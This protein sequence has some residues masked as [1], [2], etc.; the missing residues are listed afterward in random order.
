MPGP[1]SAHRI[2]DWGDDEEEALVFSKELE[3]RLNVTAHAI[4]LEAI[5]QNAKPTLEQL[6]DVQYLLTTS[7]HIEQVQKY[8]AAHKKK[9]I[10]IKPNPQIYL[11]VVSEVQNKNVGVVI[12]DPKTMHAS[13]EVFMNIFHPK[14]TKKFF[15]SPIDD[16]NQIQILLKE[17][18]LIYVSPLCW[19][20][21]RRLTPASLEIRT[22]KDFI[23][24][25]S[26]NTIRE[27]QLFE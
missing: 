14:T 2:R 10:E 21:M 20:E 11:E 12:K 25:E 5:E 16:K 24:Q 13:M 23:A 15:I 8:A 17:A 7:W 22:F 26:L 4:T 9:V 18:D 6:S 1:E 27:I 3:R 19:D